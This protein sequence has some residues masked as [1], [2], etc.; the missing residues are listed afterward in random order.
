MSDLIKNLKF[1]WKYVRNY[2]K[3]MFIY[4]FLN[5]LSMAFSIILPIFS[6]KVIVFFN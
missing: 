6:A 2:K 3:E 4:I 1:S 5:I